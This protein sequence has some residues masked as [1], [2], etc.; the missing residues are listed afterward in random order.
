MQGDFHIGSW[1]IQPALNDISGNGKTVHVELKAM[2]VLV[3]LADRAGEV[4]EKETLIRSV[5]FDAF[6]TDDVLTRSISELRKAFKDSPRNPRVIQTIPKGGY[7]LI[8]AVERNSGS[9]SSRSKQADMPGE[10]AD[11]QA[12]AYRP[13]QA[14][15][16]V[17]FLTFG[18]ILSFNLGGLRDRLMA[19]AGL[20]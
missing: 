10:N 13:F 14:A 19:A 18:F 15:A 12:A 8:A 16:G 20:R 1:L 5:W 6:V 9:S 4:V 17:A 3:T 11:R 2:R 7:R